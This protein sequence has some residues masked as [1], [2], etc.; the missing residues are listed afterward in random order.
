MALLGGWEGFTMGVPGGYTY[1]EDKPP[2]PR[3]RSKPLTDWSLASEDLNREDYIRLHNIPDRFASGAATA[4]PG[5]WYSGHADLVSINTGRVFV[6]S[7]SGRSMP[8][9]TGLPKASSAEATFDAL[10]RK[11]AVRVM[12]GPAPH[13]RINE[14][15]L[16]L[17]GSSG[18]PGG[19]QPLGRATSLPIQRWHT[20]TWSS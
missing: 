18:T 2:G 7:L 20:R 4:S 5:D 9:Q 6:I 10:P 12:T 16:V 15:K 11:G 14:D 13:D 17:A 3:A 19:W 1:T 8:S